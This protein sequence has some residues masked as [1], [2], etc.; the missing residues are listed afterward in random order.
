MRSYRRL[1]NNQKSRYFRIQE[2]LIIYKETERL[3]L[4][5]ILKLNLFDSSE[6]MKI[7][8]RFLRA[9]SRS[10]M[11]L[12]VLIKLD[13]FKDKSVKHIFLQIFLKKAREL[14]KS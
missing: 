8:K 11:L 12:K 9:S 10:Y 4:K 7:A 2:I 13:F 6:Y 5:S 1:V 3:A 14:F